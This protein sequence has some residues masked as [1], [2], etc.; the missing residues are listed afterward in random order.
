MKDM[1]ETKLQKSIERN[2]PAK[3]PGRFFLTGL[4]IGTIAVMNSCTLQTS[5][6]G[7]KVI[8]IQNQMSPDYY[9]Y[10]IDKIKN[11]RPEKNLTTVWGTAVPHHQ[12]AADVMAQTLFQL[13]DNNYENIY[14]LSPDHF[15]RGR[16]QISITE[17]PLKTATGT[18]R[19]S[20]PDVSALKKMANAGSGDAFISFEHG[21]GTPIP[22]IVAL[23]PNAQITPILIRSDA[24]KDD[25]DELITFLNEQSRKPQTLIV[26][27]SDFSHYLNAEQ[28]HQKD[29]QTIAALKQD[30]PEKILE[31]NQPDNCDSVNILY[32]M[33][34]LQELKKSKLQIYLNK[35]S[36]DYTKEPVTSTTSYITFF[37]SD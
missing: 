8:S 17:S 21:V 7:E 30:Y 34:S 37:L 31:L 13:K 3:N 29:L 5:A 6:Q 9:S 16:T 33:K 24:Q 35:N 1:K 22:F 18:T 26:E 20:P 32:I 28:A 10:M 4:L 27:S 25:L 14:I 2:G 12:L 36:Q 19:I 15:D 23:W 11:N